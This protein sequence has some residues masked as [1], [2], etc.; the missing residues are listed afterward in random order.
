MKKLVVFSGAGLSADSGIQTF[1][2]KD[3][4]WENHNVDQIASIATWKQNLTTVHRFY[5]AR[6][7]Q[8][9]EVEPNAAHLM[10]ADWQRRYGAV[11]LTQNIDDL[12][13]RAGC[14]DVVH[15]HGDLR[16]MQCK[17]CGNQW[18]VGYAAWDPSEDRCPKCSSRKG[19]KPGV[20]F[21]GEAAPHYRT[22]WR[23]F[24]ELTTGDVLVVI[25]TS[26]KVIDIGSVAAG[27]RAT[28]ILSNLE[29]SSEASMPGAPVAEDRHFHHV[30]HGRAAAIA[31][32]LDSLIQTLMVP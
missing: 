5:N 12:L 26:G 23:T 6:R 31:P 15:L 16:A 2:D 3:G 19:V 28:T 11:L 27:S 13:E 29:P 21:F 24:T 9:A 20:V 14:T 17:A 7:A 4:L 32:D 8:L 18:P 10:L 30:L 1:R 22:M 25:G